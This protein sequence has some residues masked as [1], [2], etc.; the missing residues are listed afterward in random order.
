MHTYGTYIARCDQV[1][2]EHTKHTYVD[3]FCLFVLLFAFVPASNVE[4]LYIIVSRLLY[5]LDIPPMKF[6]VYFMGYEKA[7][8]KPKDDQE[9]IKWVFSRRGTIEL[10]Q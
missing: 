7:E 9:L 10:T 6:T 4:C 3:S 8:E 2:I 5:R 1:P